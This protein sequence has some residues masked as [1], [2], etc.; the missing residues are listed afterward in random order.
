MRHSAIQSEIA[1]HPFA[2]ISDKRKEIL[3]TVSV[4]LLEGDTLNALRL[5]DRLYIYWKSKNGTLESK[6]FKIDANTKYN[7]SMLRK[8]E[9]F[10]VVLSKVV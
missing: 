6:V 8:A 1:L 9:Y 10:E 4:N 2:I 5:G 7:I 3:I